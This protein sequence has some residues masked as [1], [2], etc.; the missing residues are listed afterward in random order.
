MLAVSQWPIWARFMKKKVLK[1]SSDTATLRKNAE[2]LL[3]SYH[4]FTQKIANYLKEACFAGI[5]CAG[6]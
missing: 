1:K 2:L 5:G 4:P 3:V 6:H